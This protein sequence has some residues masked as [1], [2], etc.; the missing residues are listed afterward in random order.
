MNI[1]DADISEESKKEALAYAVEVG[2]AYPSE[3]HGICWWNYDAGKGF[4]AGWAAAKGERILNP[5]VKCGASDCTNGIVFE[6]DTA[7]LCKV[8]NGNGKVRE[9]K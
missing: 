8:C 3:K 2:L 1:Y 6:S 5:W 7:T 9:F 4:L